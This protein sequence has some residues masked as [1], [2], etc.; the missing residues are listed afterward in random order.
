MPLRRGRLPPTKTTEEPNEHE[1]NWSHDIKG[2]YHMDFSYFPDCIRPF[3]RYFGWDIIDLDRDIFIVDHGAHFELGEI[4][5]RSGNG[6][7]QDKFGYRLALPDFAP[8]SSIINL[9]F[10]PS[11][12]D[13]GLL[14]DYSKLRIE[15]LAP[16]G[17]G[18]FHP[19]TDMAYPFC[20]Y[21]PNVEMHLQGPI[22]KNIK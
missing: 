21:P 4:Q 18:C 13:A 11:V 10:E 8:E 3:P 7:H 16:K 9:D 2:T 6:L 20:P 15:T 17:I 22:V 19:K 12:L 14:D 5:A 1:G